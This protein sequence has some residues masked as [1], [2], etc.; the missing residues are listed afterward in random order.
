MNARRKTLTQRAR[1]ARGFTLVEIMIVVAI[2]GILIA[3]AVPG[4]VHAREESRTKSCQ[5]N[6]TKIDG[7]KE[8]WALTLNKAQGAAVSMADLY[9]DD[10]SSYIKNDPVCPT[11]GQWYTA[12]PVGLPPAC[13]GAWPGHVLP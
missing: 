7:A 8:Q 1:R 2:I 5:E 10:G 6:L 13:T 12:N 11:D 4:F 9:T 3:I